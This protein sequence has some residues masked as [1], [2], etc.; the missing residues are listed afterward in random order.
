VNGGELQLGDHVCWIYDSD[1]EHRKTL[2]HFVKEGLE[3]DER[4]LYLAR[5]STLERVT[6]YLQ[7]A[8]IAVKDAL[9]SGQVTVVDAEK[10]YLSEDGFQPERLADACCEESMQTIVDGYRGLRAASEAGWLVPK[11]VSPAQLVEYELRVDEVVPRLPQI[12]LCGY[13]ARYVDANWLLALQAVHTSRITSPSVRP[14]PFTVTKADAVIAVQGE[15]DWTCREAFSLALRAAAAAIPSRQEMVL[16]LIGLQFGD[17]TGL[18]SLAGLAERLD[19]EGRSLT[20]R[21][22]PEVTREI[23]FHLSGRFR[24][25]ASDPHVFVEEE[26]SLCR[27]SLDPDGHGEPRAHRGRHGLRQGRAVRRG[28][29]RRS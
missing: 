21:V 18:L 6:A 17:P 5:H 26:G 15:V 9:R 10:A 12:G 29:R 16:D 7:D 25:R 3:R 8:G 23:I 19:G 28:R 27:G 14:S 11:A 1:E 13:D 4:V 24:L 22:L 2:T 20:L